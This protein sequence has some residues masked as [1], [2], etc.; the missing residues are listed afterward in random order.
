MSKSSDSAAGAGS[1]VH[2]SSNKLTLSVSYISIKLTLWQ[3]V[4]V[5]FFKKGFG[6]VMWQRGAVNLSI[7]HFT[8]GASYK[9]SV[10]VTQFGA[11]FI[12]LKRCFQEN[13]NELFVK[14]EISF[15]VAALWLNM[16]EVEA[17]QGN[18]ERCFPLG[19]ECKTGV[20]SCWVTD[21]FP[22]QTGARPRCILKLLHRWE[23][24]AHS[25]PPCSCVSP[26][27]QDQLWI[28]ASSLKKSNQQPFIN[29]ADA[30]WRLLPH[31]LPCT[32]H[33]QHPLW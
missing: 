1:V 5:R 4:G 15:P 20:C 18:R 30:S 21:P 16:N 8:A 29:L 13:Y 11:D 9:E 12:V 19:Y 10:E 3:R 23:S 24:K 28:S 26:R 2:G 25:G 31:H 27:F 7:H 32:E 6:V 14:W 22:N 17:V 33:Q